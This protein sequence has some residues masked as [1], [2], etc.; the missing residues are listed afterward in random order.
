[1]LVLGPARPVR[2]T[3]AVPRFGALI[4]LHFLTSKTCRF[5]TKRSKTQCKK[6]LNCQ[7]A[8]AIKRAFFSRPSPR[9]RVNSPPF[10]CRSFYG[11]SM[12]KRFFTALRSVQNDISSF[13]HT[14]REWVELEKRLGAA[15]AHSSFNR[16]YSVT[17]VVMLSRKNSINSNYFLFLPS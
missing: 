15:H 2:N 4:F 11:R 3:Q 14:L 10:R 1:M 13:S 17:L 6:S 8:C 7:I 12:Q 5:K 16:T 9:E